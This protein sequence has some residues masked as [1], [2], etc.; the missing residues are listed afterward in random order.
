MADKIKIIEM[1]L[2]G[3]TLTGCDQ[4][5]LAELEEIKLAVAVMV[6]YLK[7]YEK[8]SFSAMKEL[9]GSFFIN[10]LRFH[11]LITLVVQHVIG[12]QDVVI[13]IP[14]KKMYVL[15]N[16]GYILS[17]Y[18]ANRNDIVF[19]NSIP[20]MKKIKYHG[21]KAYISKSVISIN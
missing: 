19:D 18:L 20:E 7:A 10:D 4:F 6:Q 1:A 16:W 8:I 12:D 11:R 13:C 17:I 5:F 21:S 9:F 3:K 15:D 14:K 2:S